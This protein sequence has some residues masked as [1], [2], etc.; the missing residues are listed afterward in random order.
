MLTA[1]EPDEPDPTRP[2]RMT[3]SD[4]DLLVLMLNEARAA[5]I[6]SARPVLEKR[7]SPASVRTA[8]AEVESNLP[9]FDRSAVRA[10]LEES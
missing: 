1:L 2:N 4:M 9:S 7:Y 3:D 5:F 8:M 10:I 6:N